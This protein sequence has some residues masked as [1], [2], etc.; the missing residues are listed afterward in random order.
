MTLTEICGAYELVLKLLLHHVRRT[1]KLPRPDA[2]VSKALFPVR[3]FSD[4]ID[5]QGHI[6]AVKVSQ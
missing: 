1:S 6:I 2:R 4:E 5:P 3:D